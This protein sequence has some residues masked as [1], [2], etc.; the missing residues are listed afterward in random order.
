[1]K[2]KK[3]EAKKVHGYLN[4][5]IR[6]YDDLTFLTGINGSGKTTVVRGV[7]ALI[8][9]SLDI[10]AQ[11]IYDEMSVEVIHDGEDIHI[12]STK[13]A[14][15]FILS[16]S[17][18]K[19][20]LEIQIYLEDESELLHQTQ[21]KENDY[22]RE[23]ERR[24][25]NHPVLKLVKS[26]PTPMFLGTERRSLEV[27]PRGRLYLS[28]RRRRRGKNIF[29][30]FLF[31]SIEEAAYLAELTY[32]G[33]EAKQRELTENLRRNILLNAFKFESMTSKK[34]DFK[35]SYY[36][37]IE[38]KK[39]VIKQTMK[40]LGL[41]DTEIEN[42]LNAF[43][44]KL[45]EVTEK[46]SGAKFDK[47]WKSNDPKMT[48][49]LVEWIMNKPQFDRISKI[50]DEVDKYVK[51][52][53]ELNEPI[54]KYLSNVNRFLQDSDKKIEFDDN[55]YLS[56]RL[57]ESNLV[58]ITSLSSGESQIVVIIT[59]LSFNPAAQLANVFIVDEPELSLHLRWQELFV[60]AVQDANPML[61]VILATHSP[62]IILE[63][64]EHCVD[65]SEQI[66]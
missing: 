52:I 44:D 10:L 19:E 32:R 51:G 9:P 47:A 42:D 59:H 38:S 37:D 29:S 15:R 66:K 36:K 30:N 2:I 35:S 33:T 28:S 14:D 57:K 24:N 50:I 6:F 39:S 8:S 27:V 56:V 12:T 7:S 43:F 61:Q 31:F 45:K 63:D 62:S 60:A 55:G 46:L 13:E 58:P 20:K 17:K 40:E 4:F 41:K 53:Q 65:L 23:I 22:Y 25:S 54:E 21:E 64:T 26:M 16:C 11:T 34:M 1:M 5:K 48:Q 49:A 18:V 3:F